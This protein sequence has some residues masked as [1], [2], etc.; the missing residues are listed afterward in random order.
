[1]TRPARNRLLAVLF[2]V[3]ALVAAPRLPDVVLWV[4]AGLVAPVML[5]AFLVTQPFRKARGL[6]ADQQYESAATELAAFEKALDDAP[7][8]RTFASFAVGLYTANP[9]AASRNTLGAVRLEQGKLDE[10]ERHFKK[11]LEF[12][13]GYG[14]A[15][16]NLAVLA[17]MRKDAAEA[18]LARAKAAELG[19]KPKLLAA[20][21]QDKL[22]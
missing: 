21:I 19:F 3:S 18:E 6:L 7:W 11:A 13:E 22:K 15:W 16:G 1:M 5:L 8:K 10:A 17:A 2:V 9:L 4:V 20:V 12:D 14:V